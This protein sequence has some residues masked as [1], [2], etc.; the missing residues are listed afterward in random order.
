MDGAR[1]IEELERCGATEDMALR[2]VREALVRLGGH[3]ASY[4]VGRSLAWA[5]ALTLR[6][7]L[8]ASRGSRSQPTC[9]SGR[10]SSTSASGGPMRSAVVLR[11]G[12]RGGRT[13]ARCPGSEA[14][15]T[16]EA[17]RR[18]RAEERKL[19]ALPAPQQQGLD[20]GPEADA[21]IFALPTMA[22]PRMSA[23][24]A[25]RVRDV[26]FQ[27]RRLRFVPSTTRPPLRDWKRPRFAGLCRA[28]RLPRV[29]LAGPTSPECMGSSSVGTHA[30][31]CRSQAKAA[32]AALAAPVTASRASRTR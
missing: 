16:L 13:E 12:P 31:D 25:L 22:G 18:Q 20:E 14:E 7:S 27:A 19:W 9:A 26:D 1:I 2:L 24:R 29:A 32:V 23:I 8:C 21:A 30:A 11:A 4:K 17:E 3:D 28:G 5:P 15:R 10:P 6:L